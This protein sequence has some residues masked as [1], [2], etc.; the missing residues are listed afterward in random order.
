MRSNLLISV[1]IPMYN[2]EKFISKCLEHLIHQTY[3]NLEIIIVDDGS[4]D[5]SVDI[6]RQYAA[7]DNR[8]KIISQKNAGPS[9]ALNTGLDAATGEY[10]HFHDHDDFVN[11]DYFEIMARA[12]NLTNA[13]ILCGEVHQP[14]YNFPRFAAIEICTELR[15]KIVKTQAN[16]FNPAWRYLYK[17]DFL[18]RT[19]LRYEPD[20]FGAQDYYFTKPAI[21]LANSVALVPGAIYNVVNT[22]TALGKSRRKLHS[23]AVKPGALAAH[24]RYVDF[25]ARHN[26]TDLMKMPEQPLEIHE[27]RMFNRCVSKRVVFYN[28]IRYYLF[29]I[30]VGTRR[31]IRE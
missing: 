21:V 11:L 16:K 12:V 31:F 14:D 24:E 22:D 18:A 8:I 7:H 25:M 3:D 28:K 6:C 4:C 5:K 1:V 30:N 29:G 2:A 13:D 10:I 23:A 17:R 27:Y 26:A 9:V 19:G 20:V 15:D